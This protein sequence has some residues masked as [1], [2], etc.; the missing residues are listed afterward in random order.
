VPLLDG[1]DRV[2]VLAFTLDAVDDHDRRL[3]RRLAGLVADILVTKNM[4]TDQ[5]FQARRRQPMSL[6]A[7]MQWQLLPPLMM[8]TPQVSVA[9][10]L[11]PAYEVAGDSFD[12]ALNDNILHL[13]MIDSMG[14]GLNAALMATLAVGAY[15]H[16]R[17]F[18]I[19]LDGLYAAM[20]E[21]IA[22]QFGTDR[23][24]TAQMARL[25]ARSGLLQW[26]N[27]GH[28][29]PLL[30]RNHVVVAELESPTTL[31]VGFGGARPVITDRSLE[32]NDRVLFYTDGVIE[33]DRR[34]GAEFGAT[35]LRDLVQQ[36]SNDNEPVQETVRLLS[37]ALMRE[38]GGV[39]SD[40]ATLLLLEWRGGS[41]DHLAVID[42]QS[43]AAT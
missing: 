23:F 11:E 27:A 8:T 31:P 7:E 19:G 22:S 25:D 42:N 40:D 6:S 29:A 20:D 30:V 9:G 2:G 33:E 41:V 10:A 35:R 18:E 3:T 39:T 21:A 26:V 34:G 32:P 37:R 36:V 12:Y 38:R 43:A 14:H 13:A 5:F 1:T 28:P 4:Y 17:R 16:A 15:R 24:V